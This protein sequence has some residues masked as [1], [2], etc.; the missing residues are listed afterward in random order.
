MRHI[1]PDEQGHRYQL[2]ARIIREAV[3]DGTLS[4]GDRLPSIEAMAEH[5]TIASM[6]VRRG[7][8]ILIDDNILVARSGV[9]I[10]VA[11]PPS[12]QGEENP[13]TQVARIRATLAAFEKSIQTRLSELRGDL[14]VLEELCESQHDGTAHPPAS[15]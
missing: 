10:F 13:R 2:V 9:G 4:V 14:A 15:D 11:N 8:Q 3:K 12:S 5:F 7:V 1:Y 6:T